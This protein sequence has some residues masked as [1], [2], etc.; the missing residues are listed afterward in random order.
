LEYRLAGRRD[1]HEV[2]RQDALEHRNVIGNQLLGPIRLRLTDVGFVGRFIV[3]S[4]DVRQG[5]PEK[6]QNSAHE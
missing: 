5:Q 6:N 2:I 1:A 3:S 4:M